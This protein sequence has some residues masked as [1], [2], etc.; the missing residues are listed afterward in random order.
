[1][2]K[3]DEAMKLTELIV[4]HKTHNITPE[5]YNDFRE[6]LFG[7]SKSKM[8]SIVPISTGDVVPNG[9]RVG[10]TKATRSNGSP[11]TKS[12]AWNGR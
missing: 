3:I 2:P 9:H 11:M 5:L 7:K 12:R 6:A 4:A 8:T 1:M 10:Y